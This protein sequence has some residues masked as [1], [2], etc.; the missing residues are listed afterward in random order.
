MSNGSANKN[1]YSS[2][3][4]SHSFN[5]KKPAAAATMTE[6]TETEQTET[7]ETETE[8]VDMHNIFTTQGTAYL[9]GDTTASGWD[10]IYTQMQAASDSATIFI[11]MNGTTVVPEKVLKLAYDK[12]LTLVLD[13]GNNIQWTVRGRN[14]T[15]DGLGDVD[16]AVTMG[17]SNIPQ[18]LQ[19]DVADDSWSTQMHLAHEGVFGLTALLSV[20]VGAENAGKNATLFYYDEEADKLKYMGM[21]FVEDAGTVTYAFEHA[22]DYVIVLDGFAGEGGTQGTAWLNTTGSTGVE[23]SM[24]EETAGGSAENGTDAGSGTAA[25]GVSTADGKDDTPPTGQSMNPKYIL[26]LGVMFLGIYMILTSKKEEKLLDI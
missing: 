13:M 12:S 11:M 25:A 7:K 1:P 19:K 17:T 4:S 21:E 14:M 16:F 18:A 22:S 3:S 8:T 5:N 2:G 20:N 23:D 26:C 24:Q 15:A 10:K 9:A 6:E